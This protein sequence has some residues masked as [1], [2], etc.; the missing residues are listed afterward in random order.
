MKIKWEA[1]INF[2]DVKTF[3]SVLRDF[4]ASPKFTVF[5]PVFEPGSGPKCAGWSSGVTVVVVVVAVEV[6][7]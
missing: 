7:G 4:P 1:R 5:F 2:T 3:R 6:E